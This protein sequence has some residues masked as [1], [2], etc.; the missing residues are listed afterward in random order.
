[1][2]SGL[3]THLQPECPAAPCSGTA[4][5]TAG[6]ARGQA[7]SG[8]GAAPTGLP[9]RPGAAGILLQKRT[10]IPPVS[11]ACLI[12]KEEKEKGKKKKNENREKR[13]RGKS[14]FLEVVGFISM[15]FTLQ[16]KG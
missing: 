8:A 2:P 16:Q 14:V 9:H 1:M 5:G 3:S 11:H 7:G 6:T 4:P 15:N 13:N 12:G 10:A